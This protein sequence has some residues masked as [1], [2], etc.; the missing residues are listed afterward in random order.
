M[1]IY[2]EFDGEFRPRPPLWRIALL[3]LCQLTLAVWLVQSLVSVADMLILRKARVEKMWIIDAVPWQTLKG[4]LTRPDRGDVSDVALRADREYAALNDFV[5]GGFVVGAL[6][7]LFFISLSTSLA[8]RLFTITFVQTCAAFG[9]AFGLRRCLSA[10]CHGPQVIALAATALVAAFVVCMAEWKL[11][12]MLAGVL[13]MTPGQRLAIWSC[14]MLPGS[15]AVAAACWLA[16]NE[17]G[18]QCAAA[19]AAL[20]LVANL[21]RRPAPSGERIDEVELVEATAATAAI[22]ALLL[23]A[24]VWLFGFDARAVVL[25]DKGFTRPTWAE[26]RAQLSSIKDDS[27]PVQPKINIHWSRRPRTKRGR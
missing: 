8:S 12:A 7:I 27:A 5:A 14:R 25:N 18:L 16:H 3:G 11:N 4:D 20:T 23:A 13:T 22:V 1:T 17:T 9:G 19:L 26:V 15:A 2:A 24:I 21:I 10:V 6:L